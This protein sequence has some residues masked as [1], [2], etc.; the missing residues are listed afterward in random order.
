MY[1]SFLSFPLLYG[2]EIVVFCFVLFF[3]FNF[4][5]MWCLFGENLSL[6]LCLVTEKVLEKG[7]ILL[8]LE[9]R[10]VLVCSML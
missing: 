5:L 10:S 9:I 6:R 8:H 4:F 2:R 7:R 3:F 1:V